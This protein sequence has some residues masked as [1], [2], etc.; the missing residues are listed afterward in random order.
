M[1]S[2]E[3]KSASVQP[4]NLGRRRFARAGAAAPAVLGT[5]ASQPVLAQTSTDRPPYH[6]TISGQLSGST[7]RAPDTRVC[8]Q[9]GRSPGYWKN[10]AWPAS[11]VVSKGFMPTASCSFTTTAPRG[12]FFDGFSFNGQTL[13]S[14][15]RRKSVDSSCRVIDRRES[16]FSNITSKATMLQVLNSEGGLNDT[17]L[18]ALGRAT[19]ATILNGIQWPTT[20]PVSPDRAIKMFNEVVLNGS[21]IVSPGV[22]WNENQVK[23]YFESLYGGL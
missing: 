2:E 11:T 13:T 19:V 21:T 12:T 22:A 1:S 10:H 17:S 4:V 5:L 14:A 23:N 8:N 15:F 6:C 7:S 16:G 3:T 18:K 9:Q 20:Y